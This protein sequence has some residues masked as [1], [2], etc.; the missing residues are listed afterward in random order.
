[1]TALWCPSEAAPPGSP[2]PVCSSEGPSLTYLHTGRSWPQPPQQ[3]PGPN[4]GLAQLLRG[5]WGMFQVPHYT[6]SHG[7]AMGCGRGPLHWSSPRGSVLFV[8]NKI[9]SQNLTACLSLSGC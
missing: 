8:L 6:G 4:L 2:C 3:A 7:R 9:C 1:M 5:A